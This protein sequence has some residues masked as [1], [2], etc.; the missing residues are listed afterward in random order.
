MTITIS[1][2]GLTDQR[3]GTVLA[4][5]EILMCIPS[6]AGSG[7]V[8]FAGGAADEAGDGLLSG[9]ASLHRCEA[10]ATG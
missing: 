3:E 4:L 1:K 5:A 9:Q 2:G 7:E 6:A 8:E 10:E